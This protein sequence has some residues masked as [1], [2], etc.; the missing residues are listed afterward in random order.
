MRRYPFPC[1]LISDQYRLSHPQ[2]LIAL[3]LGTLL[4]QLCP[5]HRVPLLQALWE[6]CPQRLSSYLVP[7]DESWLASS[8][9]EKK[10]SIPSS[11]NWGFRRPCFASGCSITGNGGLITVSPEAGGTACLG[12]YKITLVSEVTEPALLLHL[13]EVKE[14]GG[15]SEL[16]CYFL[17]SDALPFLPCSLDSHIQDPRK[18]QLCLVKFIGKSVQV[19]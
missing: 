19:L 7:D 6:G 18:L 5:A 12:V 17:V 2:L 10:C 16:F 9:G 3:G 1:S 13:C 11:E 8:K 15:S 4:L 14:M